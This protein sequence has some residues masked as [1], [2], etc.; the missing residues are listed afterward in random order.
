MPAAFRRGRFLKNGHRL[1][2]LDSRSDAFSSREP[3]PTSPENTLEVPARQRIALWP[4]PCSLHKRCRRV[5]FG[6]AT[7]E[8]LVKNFAPDV[9]AVAGTF[10]RAFRK[11]RY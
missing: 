3:V 6:L 8:R 4:R 10:V 9:L 7:W 1:R 11:P 5:K 2:A